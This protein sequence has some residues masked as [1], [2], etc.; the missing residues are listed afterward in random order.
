V[1]VEDRVRSHFDA[2]AKRFDAIYDEHKGPVAHLVDDVWRGVVQRRLELT[3]ERLAPFEGKRIL[4]VGTGSGRYCVAYAQRGAHAVGIDLAEA[5]ID[6]ARQH[7]RHAG[8]QDAC[9]FRVGAFPDAVTGETF[10]AASAM[11]YFDYVEDTVAHLEKMRELT[12][13]RMIVS[14]PKSRELRAPLRWLRFR[15]AGTPLFLFSRARVDAVL[16][17]AGLRGAE[18]I[19]LGRDYVVVADA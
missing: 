10:D 9:D 14:F 1:S 15:I 12:T 13:G 5:M 7:A 6:L 2:D 17:A 19:D 4:D 8:V 18:L 11:G 16:D 3:L